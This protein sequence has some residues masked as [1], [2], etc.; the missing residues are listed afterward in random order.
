M[1]RTVFILGAGASREAGSPLM[2]DFLDIAE[3]LLARGE[4]RDAEEE[5]KRVF[6]G[7][8]ALQRV[9]SKAQLDISNLEPVF[10]AFE[11]ALLFGRLGDLPDADLRA[12]APAIRRLIVRTLEKRIRYP[13]EYGPRMLPPV[14]YKEFA[15]LLESML[16]R[17]ALSVAVMTFNYDV[18]LDYALQFKSL[19]I[20]DCLH[21]SA[22]VAL[23]VMKLHG[24]LNWARCHKC[25]EIIPWGIAEF[26]RLH[27][28][29]LEPGRTVELDIASKLGTLKHCDEPLGGDPIIVPPTWNKTQ[30]HAEIATV[31]QHAA[32]HLSEAEYIYVIGYSLPL[33]DEFFRYLYALGTVGEARLKRFWVFDPDRSGTVRRRFERL[34]GSGARARFGYY[35]IRF[36]DAIQFLR[37]QLQNDP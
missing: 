26:L 5:F 4:V 3:S 17:Q 2:F 14:P 25:R 28:W 18:A 27:T 1:S 29:N 11:L 33:T 6:K 30:H 16:E 20:D 9:H 19:A 34:L 24:S 8:A 15:E 23:P 12:L 21:D 13:V 22:S 36:K 35:D 32:R 37:G 31:W 7:I 10:A